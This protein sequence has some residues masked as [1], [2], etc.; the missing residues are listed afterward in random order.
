M[1]ASWLEY[2]ATDEQLKAFND[3][4]YL[5]VENAISTEMVDALEKVADQIDAEERAKNG[6]ESHKL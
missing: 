2:C 3:T 6:L 4:G 1:D 5:I